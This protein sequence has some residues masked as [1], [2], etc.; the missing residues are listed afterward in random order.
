VLVA[1]K[2]HPSLAPSFAASEEEKREIK[3]IL[4][5]LFEGEAAPARFIPIENQGLISAL[6]TLAQP[7]VQLSPMIPEIG[8]MHRRTADAEIYFLVN[9]SNARQKFQVTFRVQNRQAERWNPLTGHCIAI[10]AERMPRGIGVTLDL[11]PYESCLIVLT[12]RTMP[13]A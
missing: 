7:D 2:R 6:Q 5:R 9:T 12:D 3:N 10:E 1:T 13:A 11:A 4:R 8:F